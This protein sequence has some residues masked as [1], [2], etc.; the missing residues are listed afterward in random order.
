MENQIYPISKKEKLMKDFSKLKGLLSNQLDQRYSK[1]MIDRIFKRAKKE[2]ETMIPK[3]PFL[4]LEKNKNDPYIRLMIFSSMTM[5]VYFALKKVLKNK[6]LARS[7]TYSFYQM[8]LP[9]NYS[10]PTA[11]LFRWMFSRFD[12]KQFKKESKRKG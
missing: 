10:L 1:D 6:T 4:N 12:R 7:L 11:M 9:G 3:M 5:A 8:N 2:F